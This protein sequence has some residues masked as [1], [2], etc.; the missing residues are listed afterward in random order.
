MKLNFRLKMLFILTLIFSTSFSFAE[1]IDPPPLKHNPW[2]LIIYRP[3]NY[4]DMNDVRCWIKIEDA[5]TGE[6]ITYNTNRIKATYEWTSN[7]IKK[8]QLYRYKRTYYL[9]GGMAM[10]LNL[11]PG[12]YRFSVFTPKDDTLL[13]E[14]PNKNDW[15][16]NE[17]YYDTENPAKVIWVIPTA[18]DNGFYK[19]GWVIDYHSPNFYKYTKPKIE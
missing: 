17:F 1:E 4:G 13:V 14:T 18:N 5:E 16:S 7:T 15:I 11:R 8:P 19:G 6:D 9:S 3:E 10:H 2:S 12:K